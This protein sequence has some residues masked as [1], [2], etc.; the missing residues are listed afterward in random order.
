MSPFGE[1]LAFFATSAVV[2]VVAEPPNAEARL[3]A[4]LRGAVEPLVHA[5]EAVQS[6]RVGGIGVVD[7]AVLER[8]RAHARPLARVGGGVGSSHGRVLRV[9]QR[10][11]CRVQ[12]GTAALVVVFDA[13]LALLFFG[14]RDVEVEV[15]VA[16]VRGCP[17]KRPPHPPLVGPELL[18]RRIRD[19]PEHHVVVG[20]VNYEP[21]EA[22]RDRRA[23]RTTCRVVGPEH[24]VIDEELRAP[25]EEVRQRGAPLVGLEAILLGDPNPRQ[26]SPSPSQLV[27]AP[28]EFLSARSSSIRAFSHSS[29]VPVLCVV[30]VFLPLR[31]MSVLVSI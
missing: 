21:V 20:Q 11:L 18:E 28:G 26:L 19:R 13:S 1:N 9:G 12:R 2:L 25:S 6:A 30:I 14:D 3:V 7:N 27:A 16:A 5:P 22:V 31:R 29:R 17:G 10:D 23:R 15:E 4:S 24:K 8:E